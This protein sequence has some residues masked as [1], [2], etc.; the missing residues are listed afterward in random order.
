M[1]QTLILEKR[2][3]VSKKIELFRFIICFIDPN[4]TYQSILT[5]NLMSPMILSEI[6]IK[7]MI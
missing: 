3:K 4:N 1:I 6:L 2:V 5:T 7:T